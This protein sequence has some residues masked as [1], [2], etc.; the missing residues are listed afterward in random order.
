M[1]SS[2]TENIP[3]RATSSPLITDVTSIVTPVA[4]PTRPLARSRR[5]GSISRVTIVIIAIIRTLPAITPNM[6]ST[7]NNQS[8]MLEARVKASSG[9][10]R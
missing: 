9:A 4:V 2:S 10:I 3:S 7:M 6:A 5:S 1:V 8:Q